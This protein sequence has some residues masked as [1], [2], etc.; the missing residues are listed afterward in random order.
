ME[1]GG[2]DSYH[3]VVRRLKIDLKADGIDP[4]VLVENSKAKQYR[5]SVPPQNVTIDKVMV[6]RHFPKGKGILEDADAPSGAKA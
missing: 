3:Q 2:H 5:L 4:D 6:M 1:L